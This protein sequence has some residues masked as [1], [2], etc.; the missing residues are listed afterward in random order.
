MFFTIIFLNSDSIIEAVSY[1][2]QKRLKSVPQKYRQPGNT[3]AELKAG[4]KSRK[5]KQKVVQKAAKESAKLQNMAHLAN[6]LKNVTKS[7]DV[8][9]ITQN[10]DQ[11]AVQSIEGRIKGA[12]SDV[13]NAETN[14]QLGVACD[15]ESHRNEFENAEKLPTESSSAV[16]NRFFEIVQEAIDCDDF[17]GLDLDF[18]NDSHCGATNKDDPQVHNSIEIEDMETA[19]TTPSNAPINNYVLDFAYDMSDE[20]ISTSTAYNDLL[21]DLHPNII[22]LPTL[23]T[24]NPAPLNVLK[25]IENESAHK[26]KESPNLITTTNQNHSQQCT[27]KTSEQTIKIPPASSVTM[28]N[29]SNSNK[30]KCKIEL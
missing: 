6:V 13:C 17:I 8:A 19:A 18:M 12:L 30:G 22:K 5:K 23:I 11:T 1:Q 24:A 27:D 2:E 14:T 3:D 7:K 26:T 20:I 4:E 29:Q 16:S 28:T 9:Q 15:V 10:N 21:P 25:S